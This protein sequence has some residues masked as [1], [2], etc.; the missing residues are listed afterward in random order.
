MYCF[1]W[2]S[3]IQIALSVLS[4]TD[5]LD[6]VLLADFSVICWLGATL[7]ILIFWNKL[8]HIEKLKPSL[9][10]DCFNKVTND[11]LQREIS[12]TSNG[13]FFA[14][15]NK[16]ILQRVTSDFF[17]QATS[18]ASNDRILQRVTSDF[19][20]RATSATSNERIL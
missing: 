4:I 15:S 13:L 5:V 2:E 11:F 17:Q 7:H 1:H 6:N 19:L 3:S 16:G 10:F 9:N 8:L 12:A 18:A 14:T 20:Q